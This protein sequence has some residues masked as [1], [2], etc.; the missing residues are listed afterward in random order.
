[1][2]VECKNYESRTYPNGETVR[3]CNLDLA[4]DAPWR[5]PD[6]CPKY[7]LRLADM[8]WQ[9]GTLVA[10]TTP[11]EPPGL[12]DG[13]AAALLDEAEDVINSAGPEILA[14]VRAEQDRRP[15]W[16]RLRRKP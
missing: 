2:K 9:Y 16:R 1:M 14:E 12:D 15:F 5:C 7:E 13:S 11:E 4:P 3:K 10:P 8:G 6:D